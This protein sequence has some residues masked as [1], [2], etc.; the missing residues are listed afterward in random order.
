V[1]PLFT[2]GHL[3]ATPGTLAPIGV[4]GDDLSTYLAAISPAIGVT[5][6]LMTGRR[7]NFHLSRDFG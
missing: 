4:S 3:V 5:L 1:K 2:L 6:T 7:I